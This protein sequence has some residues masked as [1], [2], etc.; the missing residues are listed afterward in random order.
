MAAATATGAVTPPDAGTPTPMTLSEVPS[1]DDFVIY[2]H[3][4]DKLVCWKPVIL[5]L[6]FEFFGNVKI[7][8]PVDDLI[9]SLLKAQW[10]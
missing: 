1:K 4:K 3:C 9:Y 2:M 10:Q 8:I 5:D 6:L 7:L